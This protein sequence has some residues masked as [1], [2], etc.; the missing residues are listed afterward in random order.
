[1]RKTCGPGHGLRIRGSNRAL[2]LGAHP[3][4]EVLLRLGNQVER[5]VGVFDLHVHDTYFVVAHF[6]YVLIGGV[7]HD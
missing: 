1:V 2:R 4:I 3:V 6:H 7:S 5:H